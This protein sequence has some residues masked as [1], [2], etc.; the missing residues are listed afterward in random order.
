MCH[1][2]CRRK[3]RP[4]ILVVPTFPPSMSYSSPIPAL[5][6]FNVLDPVQTIRASFRSRLILHRWSH[7]GL[8]RHLGLVVACQV[9]EDDHRCLRASA[10]SSSSSP[11]PFLS[12]LPL[13]PFA[14]GSSSKPPPRMI[15]SSRFSLSEQTSS[16]DKHKQERHGL[17]LEAEEFSG[18]KAVRVP[19]FHALFALVFV[20]EASL[21]LRVARYLVHLLP[22][23][24]LG[25]F[26]VFSVL[27]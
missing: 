6:P 3:P 25:F 14:L 19:I 13:S 17:A 15:R 18:L 2:H 9:D 7:R 27:V 26:V 4:K 1:L 20:P 21:R 16:Y 22:P 10:F 11:C 23:S 24:I 8:I 5:P 12:P